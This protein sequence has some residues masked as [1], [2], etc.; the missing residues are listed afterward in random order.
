MR[1]VGE[2]ADDWVVDRI[3]KA[4]EQHQGGYRSHTDTEHVGVE[5]H[6]KVSDEHP[7]KVTSHVAHAIGE[8]ADQGNFSWHKIPFHF[9]HDKFY[10]TNN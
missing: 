2:R 6:Q 4:R 10:D 5:D 8:L 7:T 1:P 9:L 3:P